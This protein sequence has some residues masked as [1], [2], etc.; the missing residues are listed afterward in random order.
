MR[1][2]PVVMVVEDDPNDADLFDLAVERSGHDVTVIRATDGE[3]A[4]DRLRHLDQAER[5]VFVVVFSDITMP[6]MTGIELIQ[7]VRHDPD[8]H[9]VPVVVFTNSSARSDILASYESGCNAYLVKPDTLSELVSS[10]MRALD[11]WLDPY[12]RVLT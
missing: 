8:L 9:R 10:V 3:Q 4:L 7:S 11:F 5:E 2:T 1:E 6:R 12:M